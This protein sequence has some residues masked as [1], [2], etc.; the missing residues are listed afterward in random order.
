MVGSGAISGGTRGRGYGSC[1]ALA[2]KHWR[3][4]AV[5]GYSVL[6]VA[7]VAALWFLWPQADN[8]QLWRQVAAWVGITSAGAC[9]SWAVVVFQRMAA[10]RDALHLLGTL[11]LVVMALSFLA[12]PV[13]VWFGLMAGVQAQYVAWAVRLCSL[14]MFL[15]YTAIYLWRRRPGGME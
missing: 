1:G 15:P 10:N 13:V 9:A 8:P 6:S 5:L 11:A 7:T 2:V 4:F 12:S 14:L 3:W